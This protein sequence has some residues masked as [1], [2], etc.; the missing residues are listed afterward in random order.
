MVLL[1]NMDLIN[2]YCIKI[3][4]FVLRIFNLK[5]NIT[6]YMFSYVCKYC[7]IYAIGQN[8]TNYSSCAKRTHFKKLQFTVY[9]YY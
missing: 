3:K 2:K 1:H 7:T 8:F 6:I 5:N 4:I 9:N